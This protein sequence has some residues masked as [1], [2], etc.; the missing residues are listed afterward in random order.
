M[1]A[2]VKS[3]A[4]LVGD[5]VRNYGRQFTVSYISLWILNLQ[6]F[7]NVSSKMSEA[8][9]DETAEIIAVDYNNLNLADINLVFSTAKK[10]GYGQFYG[11]LDGQMILGWFD[12]Y[13]NERREVAADLSVREADAYKGGGSLDS[14]ARTDRIVAQALKSLRK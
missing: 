2:C 6:S 14:P 10:G 12:K 4:P 3:G 1:V 7:V 5:I 9:I 11:R 13:F 8:Q